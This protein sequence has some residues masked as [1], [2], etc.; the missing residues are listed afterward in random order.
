MTGLPWWALAL[1][2]IGC[3]VVGGLIGYALIMWYLYKSFR[4]TH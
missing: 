3:L 2:F 4:D 1:I